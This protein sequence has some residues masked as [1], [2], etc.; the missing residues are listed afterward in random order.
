MHR[1]GFV[2]ILGRPNV[3]KSTLLNALLGERLVI[4]SSKPQTTRHRIFGIHNEEDMQIVFS[5]TPGII[6]EPKYNMQAIMNRWAYSVFD[7]SDVLL[8]MVDIYE[9]VSLDEQ[10]KLRLSNLSVPVL[11]LINKI[12]QSTEEDVSELVAQWSDIYDWS[13]IHPVS[14][15][16]GVGIEPLMDVIKNHI[17][18]SPPYFPKDDMSD[19]PVR[20][21]ISEIIREKIL[22]LYKQEIPY[23]CEVQVEQYQEEQKDGE[24]FTRIEAIVYVNR[25]SQKA[26]VIGKGGVAIKRLGIAARESI[27]EFI[28][29]QIFLRLYVKVREGWRDDET[30][31]RRFGYQ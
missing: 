6:S 14:A 18:E 31:L 23:S 2:N 29:H 12:D 26:I 21:F 7:D 30:K 8:L 4:A 24:A 5:D 9:P 28:G 13:I 17:P 10:L 1:A 3:G 27:E 20:F 25:Q 22:E 19:R 11:L 15:L 16:Q